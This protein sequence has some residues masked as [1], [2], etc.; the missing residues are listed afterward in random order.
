M[1]DRIDWGR[2]EQAI[3]VRIQDK[4]RVYGAQDMTQEE[5]RALVPSLQRN[6]AV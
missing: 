4:V 1:R 6:E 3:K 2:R 5:L